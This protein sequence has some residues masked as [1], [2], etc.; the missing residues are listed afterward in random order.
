MS[1]PAG[2]VKE[3]KTLLRA[4]GILLFIFIIVLAVTVV[5]VVSFNTLLSLDEDL[6]AEWAVLEQL[7]DA[8]RGLTA[9]MLV[10][11]RATGFSPDGQEGWTS[12]QAAADTAPS[13]NEE[14]LA[15]AAL[16][17]AVEELLSEIRR[18]APAVALREIE[19]SLQEAGE[20]STQIGIACRRY[21]EAVGVYEH[22]L[23]RIPNRWLAGLFGFGEVSECER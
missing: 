15:H 13:F 3:R 5:G 20:L 17:D 7:Q 6:R 22:E 23:H 9:D 2:P 14:V 21:N 10:A 19:A 1:E 11:L 18:N 12:A 4:L 16:N 8:R